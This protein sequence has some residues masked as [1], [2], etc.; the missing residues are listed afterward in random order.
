MATFRT[1]TTVATSVAASELYRGDSILM[2]PSVSV[3]LY[4]DNES[5]V[6]SQYY[7]YGKMASKLLLLW[8]RNCITVI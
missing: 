2:A 1:A 4:W 8:L 5:S 3:A 7:P 6:G